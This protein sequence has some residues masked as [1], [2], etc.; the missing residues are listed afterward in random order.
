MRCLFK[1]PE[2][3]EFAMSGEG[4]WSVLDMDGGGSLSK[5]ELSSF[6]NND[7]LFE[8]GQP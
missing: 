5:R 1:K 4:L 6:I 2:K 3:V 8:A 7:E